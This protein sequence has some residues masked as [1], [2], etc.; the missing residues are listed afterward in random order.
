MA[1]FGRW[2]LAGLAALVAASSPSPIAHPDALQFGAETTSDISRD[3][4][5]LLQVSWHVALPEQSD[6]AP[7]FVSDID[8]DG[9]PRDLLIVET[10]QGQ[11]VAIDSAT[12]RTLWQTS[13]P[14]GVHW[15]TST[16][17]VDPARQFV[18][19]YCLDG[20]IHKYAIED[21]REATG[22][23][24]PQLIT[25]KTEVEK[26]SSA[27]RIATAGNGHTYL[28]MPMAAYPDPGDEGD[29]QGHVTTIDLGQGDQWV[30][31]AACSD[32]SFH[33]LPTLDE[34]DCDQQQSGIWA[35]AGVVYDPSLDRIFVTV[36]NGVYDASSGGFNWGTSV[37]ALKP[38]G[39]T[40]DGVPLDS[41]TPAEYQQLTDQDL[42]LSASAVEI[43]PAGASSTYPHLGIQ[44]GKDGVLRLL[45][46]ADLSGQG[47]P[48][49]IGGELARIQ[50]LPWVLTRPVAWRDPVSGA[51][52]IFVT[53]SRALLAFGI[54]EHEDKTMELVQK[55]S[56]NSGGTSPVLA[57][58]LLF[59]AAGNNLYAVDV[60]SGVLIWQDSHIG[61]IHWQ[62]P[63]VVGSSIYICDGNHEVWRY[64][65][66][67]Q[68][69]RAR[70]RRFS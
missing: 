57:N 2:V 50:G 31:N 29:Y 38:D 3:E 14:L 21:G 6:G 39:S 10:K 56:V 33:L 36:G 24:W 32:K 35:R 8:I 30:F 17:A 53:N 27:I 23:G 65:V 12:G 48:R 37:V 18:Y 19:A 55:W 63:I 68:A 43:L 58:G 25:T 16:P 61:P 62:T 69:R 5:D 44:I 34:N 60:T 52:S 26:G 7:L 47:G 22:G 45:N 46:L 1:P 49:H 40:D 51:T 59:Y 13:Q 54:V 66:T 15:T 28:Y 41:Y 70:R 67:P 4:L 64:D 9:T 11:V 42:D 20:Y